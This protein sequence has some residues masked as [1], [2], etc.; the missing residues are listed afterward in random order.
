MLTIPC[1]AVSLL[2]QKGGIKAG[3]FHVHRA[4]QCLAV[5]LA[6]AGFILAVVSFSVPWSDMAPGTAPHEL[7]N[8]H[9]VLGV[10]VMILSLLQ[11]RG[12]LETPVFWRVRG[13]KE[14]NLYNLYMF[15]TDRCM[16]WHP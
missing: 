14:G 15:L 11:V 7:Y 2:L 4:V 3:W 9:R 6:L 16:C 1:S 8:A 10:I 12:A 5:L 13:E